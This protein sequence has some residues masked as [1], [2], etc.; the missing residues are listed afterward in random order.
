MTIDWHKDPASVAEAVIL[1]ALTTQRDG[2]LERLATA[3]P[4]LNSLLAVQAQAVVLLQQIK[5]VKA[6]CARAMRAVTTKGS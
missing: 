3:P 4:D 2:I 5:D 1:K 6:E